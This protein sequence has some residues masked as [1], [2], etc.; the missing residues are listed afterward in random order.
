MKTILKVSMLAVGGASLGYTLNTRLRLEQA[1]WES[2]NEE[3]EEIYQKRAQIR[4]ILETGVV[5]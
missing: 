5:S 2:I 3:Q 1:K 4:S